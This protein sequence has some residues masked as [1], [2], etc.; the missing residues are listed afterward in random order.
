MQAGSHANRIYM[1]SYRKRYIQEGKKT[2]K[3]AGRWGNRHIHRL[4]GRYAR[5]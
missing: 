3:Q 5:R 1:Q 4:T 2:D